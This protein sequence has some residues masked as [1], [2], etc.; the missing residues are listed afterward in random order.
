MINLVPPTAKK[1]IIAEYWVR[2]VSVWLLILSV[3]LFVVSLFLLPVYVL[4]TSQVN[5]Y[6]SSANE[7]TAKVAEYDLS[8][9]A[10]AQTNVQSQA[11]FELRHMKKFS[12]LIENF[13]SLMGTE[14]VV[15][16][17]EFK[18][19]GMKLDSVLINGQA[20]DR[21][22][23]ADYRDNLLKLSEVKDVHLPI[24]NLAKD[25]DITFSISVTLSDEDKI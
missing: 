13:N 6:A 11:L 12:D 14:I 4:V 8:A 15:T 24:A 19:S 16:S 17:M 2:V 25:R 21:K 20:K 1:K 22:A 9:S 23:L 18:R 5:V 10:L 3:M 7:A